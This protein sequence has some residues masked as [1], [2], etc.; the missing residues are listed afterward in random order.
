MRLF[1]HGGVRLD[2]GTLRVR[3]IGSNGVDVR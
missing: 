1:K 2:I 3:E